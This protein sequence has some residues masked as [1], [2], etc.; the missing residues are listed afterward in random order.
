[1]RNRSTRVTEFVGGLGFLLLLSIGLA[2]CGAPAAQNPAPTAV[3]A[4]AL[5]VVVVAAQ[6]SVVPVQRVTVAFKT[7]GRVV[8]I[9]VH[10]GETVKQGTVLARLSDAILEKQI[11]A[12]QA[13]VAL[14]QKQL[15]Q[16]KT[17][18]TPEQTAAAQVTLDAAQKNYDK[19]RA[20]PTV[21]EMA[22]L[23]AQ[24]DNAKA[25][26]DQAQAAYDRIGGASNPDIAM[27]PQSAALQQA[28]NSYKAAVAAYN[29]AATHPT[30]AELAAAKAQVQ[31]AQEALTRLQPT[32]EALDVAQ[33]QV[34]NAQAALDLAK[35]QAADAILVAPFDGIVAAKNIEQG[36]VVQAGAPAFDLG[37]QSRLQV[38]TK[39]LTEVDAAKI[40]VGQTASVT[41]DA[42]PGK[43]LTGKV[44]SI[45]PEAN[46][47]RGDQVYKVTI[48]LPDPASMG[49]RWGMTANVSIP[50]NP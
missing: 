49:L 2:G 50:V 32:R 13:A 12:A 40:T 43:T 34:D 15:V 24:A 21:D 39:D 3:K 26:V 42:L 44:A 45:S 35:A 14:A 41:C 11:A 38:E 25:A 36:Q 33:A 9:P 37:D 7:G 17:G 16:L 30:A 28:T 29:D 5:D 22:Q 48:S 1:M 47:Y 23:K 20:G 18:G 27:T 19:V 46:D 31:Q 8:D 6:G 10:E 4:Q